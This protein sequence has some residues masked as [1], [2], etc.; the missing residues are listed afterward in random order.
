MSTAIATV[1]LGGGGPTS[2]C[3]FNRHTCVLIFTVR[4]VELRRLETAIGQVKA[5]A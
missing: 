1:A 4:R 5:S 3:Q 2:E